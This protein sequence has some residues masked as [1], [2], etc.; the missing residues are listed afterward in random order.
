MSNHTVERPDEP[1]DHGIGR[2]RGGPTTKIHLACDA[3]RRPLAVWLTPGNVNDV[4]ELPRVLDRVRVPRLGAGRP[5]TRPDRVVADKGYSSKANRALLRRRGIAHTIPE[6]DDQL[7][8][9]RRRGSAGGRPCGFD[10]DV[11]RARNA[12]ERTF[13]KLKQWRGIATRY[14][15]TATNYRGAIHLCSLLIWLADT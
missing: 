15:K 11:Y 12:I 4:T 3:D 10:R 5:R 7:A 14:D 8:N 9:R 6:R 2:S 1:A 13:N